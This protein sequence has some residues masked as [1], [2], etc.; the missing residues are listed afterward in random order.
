MEIKNV[1]DNIKKFKIALKLFL[2]MYSFY[3]LK[4]YCNQS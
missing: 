1:N 3:T 4:E 2:C